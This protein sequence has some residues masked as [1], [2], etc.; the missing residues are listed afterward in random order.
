MVGIN[1]AKCVD[2]KPNTMWFEIKYDKYFWWND[3][4]ITSIQLS[5]TTGENVLVRTCLFARGEL[6]TRLVGTWTTS[7]CR[8]NL[9]CLSVGGII[10]VQSSGYQSF[11]GCLIVGGKPYVCPMQSYVNWIWQWLVRTSHDRCAY[12]YLFKIHW[13]KIEGLIKFTPL[14]HISKNKIWESC[15]FPVS[16]DIWVWRVA[17]ISFF[18]PGLCKFVHGQAI[19]QWRRLLKLLNE[20]LKCYKQNFEVIFAESSCLRA[21]E[22][23]TNALKNFHYQ[24]FHII[25]L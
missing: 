17:K 15:F 3:G 14:F 2:L 11:R 8:Q 22:L 10:G 23:K 21:S 16:I 6:Q 20:L 7:V 18:C 24:I 19:I 13:W 9:L 1:L 12:P 5:R 25:W 4:F